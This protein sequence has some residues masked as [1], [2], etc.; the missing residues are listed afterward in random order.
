[1]GWAILGDRILGLA[2]RGQVIVWTVAALGPAP[3][4]SYASERLGLATWQ[5]GLP[6]AALGIGVGLGC[7]AAG[8][9]SASKVEYGLLPLGAIGLTLTTLAF[10]LLG[11]GV[12]GTIVLMGMIGVSSGL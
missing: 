3:V 8:R 1:A 4:Y 6:M 10:A 5:A 12:V 11:P 2:V 9:L 7:V